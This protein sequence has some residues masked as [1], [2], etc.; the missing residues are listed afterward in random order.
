MLKSSTETVKKSQR[1]FAQSSSKSTG[2]NPIINPRHQSQK[3][4]DNS[5]YV[6]IDRSPPSL[7]T[8]ITVL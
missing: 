7:R 5:L 4:G 8:Y 3:R 2:G 1:Y 6:L